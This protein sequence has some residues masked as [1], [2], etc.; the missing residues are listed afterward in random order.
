MISVMKYKLQFLHEPLLITSRI[1]FVLWR[2]LAC[3]RTGT[4]TGALL[5]NRW[6]TRAKSPKSRHSNLNGKNNHACPDSHTNDDDPAP[7]NIFE[8]GYSIHSL[9]LI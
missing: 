1:P 5:E 9:A 6:R 7:V 4:E 3:G 2:S 8:A